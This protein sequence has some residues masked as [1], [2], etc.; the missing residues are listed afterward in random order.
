M[1]KPKSPSFL[2][3]NAG[4]SGLQWITGVIGTLFLILLISGCPS[5]GDNGKKIDIRGL[6]PDEAADHVADRMCRY[7][8]KC[9]M[10]TYMCSASTD[11]DAVCVGT[12]E[13]IPYNAC[14]QALREDFRE[15]LFCEKLSPEEQNLVNKCFNQMLSDPCLTQEQ[16]DANADAMAAGEEPPYGSFMSPECMMLQSVFEECGDQ[17]IN[18]DPPDWDWL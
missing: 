7:I 2:D 6:D 10:I 17:N 9:G 15:E 18:E 4:F 3:W 8:D 14:Y 1:R 16:V 5:D 11:E 12:I 13:Q